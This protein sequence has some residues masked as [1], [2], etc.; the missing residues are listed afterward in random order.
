MANVKQSPSHFETVNPFDGEALQSFVYTNRSQIEVQ[1][2]HL[3]K[4]FYQWSRSSW[5]F[6]KNALEK[7]K[8]VLLSK[9]NQLALQIQLE[10]GKS[11]ED[12]KLEINKSLSFFD[13]FLNQKSPEWTGTEIKSQ[14][15]T[16]KIQFEPL[17]IVFV[18][19]PWNYP[20]WQF[21]RC[22]LSVWVTGNVIL[23]KT[24]EITAGV[25]FLIQDIVK[26]AG[27]P[28]VIETV[29]P[30]VE[31]IHS[32]V[33]N[34]KISALAFTGST[35][36]G[37]DLAI[38]AAEALK[39]S[40][41]ELGGSD[42]FIAFGNFDR[43]ESASLAVKSRMTNNG[44]S[45]IAS[46]RF[47]IP[48]ECSQEWMLFVTEELKRQEEESKNID[49]R[50]GLLSSKKTQNAYFELVKKLDSL[51]LK[52]IK[53]EV[54]KSKNGF[55]VDPIFYFVSEEDLRSNTELLDFFLQTEIFC[56]IGL[57][58]SYSNLAHAVELINLSP[59]GLGATLFGPKD[60]PICLELISEIKV[61]MVAV[62]DQLKS[63]PRVPFGGI[64]QSGWGRESG[65]YGW[66]EFVNVKVI[67]I[68]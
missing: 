56:P 59:Y 66:K 22:A 25:G 34:K 36:V 58:V 23:Y 8:N 13:Y 61:G 9:K 6:K 19:M 14:Y 47:F 33:K 64:K 40:V 48:S 21:F 12:A 32:V 2:G 60:D 53:S 3:E 10:M 24:A 30:L 15:S 55:F 52:K 44:Q 5:D 51:N 54:C 26:Q 43:K 16:T 49:L 28:N 68:K 67:G 39:K 45:C 7:I 63:D 50:I 20:V 17:G 37:R 27:V 29:V 42:A 4:G 11:L 1:I 41:L 65:E 57:V 35:S 38:S 18:I 62:N 46:K 31:E